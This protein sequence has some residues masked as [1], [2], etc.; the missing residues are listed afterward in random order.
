MFVIAD[1]EWIT[2]AEGHHSP[3]Q[4]AGIRVDEKWNEI[5]SFKSFI[6]P[7]DSEFHE[8]N[9]VAY[10]G[11]TAS[12]FLHA[13]NAH[14]VLTDFEAWLE[15][16]DIV[17]WWYAESEKLFNKIY[18]LILKRS[19]PHKVISI[20]EHIYEFLSGQANSRG[21]S[22]RIAKA[23]GIDTKS[24][25]KHYSINDANV[26]VQLMAVIEYPQELLL[27]PL[28][29]KEKVEVTKSQ[30]VDLPYQ[31]EISTNTIH[32]KECEHLAQNDII[33]VGHK[34]LKTAIKK[35]CNICE[36]CKD[37]VQL[38]IRERNQDIIDRTQY[39]YIYSP[40][41]KV[42]HKYSCGVMLAAK[43]I[44]GT[45]TYEG[46]LKTGKKPCKLCNPTPHDTYKPIPEQQKIKRL[47]KKITHN[48]PKEEAKAVKRQRIASAERYTKL[49]DKTLSKDERD[50]IYTLT[51]P[52]FAFFVGK[53]Y[54][55]FHL[56]SCNKLK[57]ISGIKGYKTYSDAIHAGFTPCRK[58]K[59]TT[60]NDVK[61]SIPITSKI[62]AD[63][64]IEDLE[65]LCKD[66]KYDFQ[67]DGKYCSINTP[68]GR[69][70]LNISTSPIKTEHINLAVSPYA[71]T[72][73]KQPRVFLSFIDA[74][75]YIKRHD[76]ELIKKKENGHVFVKLF[77]D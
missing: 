65:Q 20:S 72:Y 67:V 42:Y 74:F 2:N 19:N 3:T 32:V 60:K 51:Q 26:I 5:S 57:E 76:S 12:D 24:E 55:T 45:R 64:R 27:K 37:A 17:L 6:R 43:T 66:M 36:C 44:L 30:L 73:H 31:Y 33:T 7:R 49:K 18:S 15:E 14:N 11:G 61:V 22:Y 70:R 48:V 62:R 69:W 54:Q 47:E 75:D 35:K 53:G 63:E 46:I 9:H 39:T 4:L 52:E 40:K 13:R 58:C 8:W 38:A 59:P 77:D 71:K 29:K 21:N 50:D 16:D 68:V 23:R 34:T 41:S 28:V 1:I 56:R 25:L 10:T